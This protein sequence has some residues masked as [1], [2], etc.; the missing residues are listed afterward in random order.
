MKNPG[1]IFLLFIAVY[2]CNKPSKQENRPNIIVIYTDDQR[3]DAAG[4]NGNEKIITPALDKIASKGI[5][6]TNANVVFSLCSPSRAALLTGRYGSANG[7]LHL[8]SNLNEGEKTIANY[9]QQAG[10]QTAVSGKW[11]IGQSPDSVG[12]DFH[13]YFEGN[14]SYYNRS[15]YDLGKEIRPEIHC[16]DYCVTRSIDFLKDASKSDKPF[17]LYHNTQ[18]PHM[19]GELIWDAKPETREK[20]NSSELPVALSRN[21]DLTQ[22]PEYLKTVRNLMQAV[23]YGYP[24]SVAIQN[25]TRD[26]YSVITEMDNSLARLFETIDELG[27][28]ENTYVFFMGDNGWMLGEHGFTSKVLPYR[29]STHVP[30]F[31]VGPDLIPDENNSLALNIDIAPTILELSGIRVPE[32]IHGKSLLPLFKN[33]TLEWRNSF[34]YEGLGNYG[35]TKPNLTALSKCYR[36]IETYDD[37]KLEMVICRELY[38]QDTDIEEMKNLAQD[39]LL[40]IVREELQ[41]EIAKHKRLVLKMDI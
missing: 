17:F 38:S 23:V 39:S 26:Y 2:S 6:F 18:L 21:D 15:I 40:T 22:K 35:G 5:R 32:N 29:P 34:I 27:L 30:F 9:L 10:Y 28:W 24:D 16:D 3:Y 7:V 8:S 37:E 19:N 31:V 14:G 36:Y 25:H 1:I 4:F 33:D 13:V 20:Y 12:F 11:H 41:N